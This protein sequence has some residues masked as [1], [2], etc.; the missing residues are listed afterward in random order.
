ML[1]GVCDSFTPLCI[2]APNSWFQHKE[3]SY[4]SSSFFSL[5]LMSVLSVLHTNVS[6]PSLLL[7]SACSP[8]SC[9]TLYFSFSLFQFILCPWYE[10]LLFLA[11]TKKKRL[12]CIHGLKRA[13]L[14]SNNSLISMKAADLIHCFCTDRG[15]WNIQG[16]GFGWQNIRFVFPGLNWLNIEAVRYDY[17]LCCIWTV[18]HKACTFI[19]RRQLSVSSAF[20]LFPTLLTRKLFSLVFASSS[21]LWWSLPLIN[22]AVI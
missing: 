21:F 2:P 10:P 15:G 13:R 9:A 8:E 3:L 20:L 17:G 19:F 6:W 14:W 11:Q 5:M 4:C 16:R 22:D 1:T 12:F 7:S 18:R